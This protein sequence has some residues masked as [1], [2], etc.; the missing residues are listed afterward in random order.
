MKHEITYRT[1]DLEI[2]G[3]FD[4]TP[5]ADQ[6]VQQGLVSYHIEPWQGGSSFARFNSARSFS[7]PDSDIAE[8]LT[9]IEALDQHAKSLWSTCNERN[10]DIAYD[11]G[12]GPWAFNQQLLP[13]TLA[14]I[15]T[16]QAGI[17]IT[18]YPMLE[19]DAVIAAVAS[20]KKDKWIKSQIGKPN[21][22]GT[23]HID[24]S[25]LKK[26]QEEVKVTLYGKAKSVF[27]HCLMELNVEGEWGIKEIFQKEMKS[28]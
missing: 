14:R 12:D 8:M 13:S 5:I 23:H 2:L 6:M 28:W 20:L 7:N 1:T 9:A 21:G 19:T 24:S 11:C 22:H 27:V 16:V 10:F 26:N 15:A 25:A 18:I 17:V 4:L 3:T